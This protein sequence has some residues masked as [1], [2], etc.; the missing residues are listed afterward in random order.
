MAQA[1]NAGRNR[2]KTIEK[3]LDDSGEI[4]PTS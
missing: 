3:A 4:D 1:G 2:L